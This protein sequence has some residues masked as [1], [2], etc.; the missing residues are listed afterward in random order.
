MSETELNNREEVSQGRIRKIEMEMSETVVG[1]EIMLARRRCYRHHPA[2][3]KA[4]DAVFISQPIANTIVA[5]AVLT[6][7]MNFDSQRNIFLVDFNTLVV[8]L[9]AK[10]GHVDPERTE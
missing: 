10:L 7:G 9:F 3:S 1:Y 2:C 4:F 6:H 5:T 8:E